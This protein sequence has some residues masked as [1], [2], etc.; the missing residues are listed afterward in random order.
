MRTAVLLAD[1]HQLFRDALRV[2]LEKEPTIAVVAETG[3]GLEVVSLAQKA[4]PDVVCMDINLPGMNGIE[5]TRHLLACCPSIKV[6]GLSAFSDQR[7]ISEM[8]GAGASGYITKAA[9]GEQLLLA[10]KAVLLGQKYLCPDA[11][12]TIS[13]AQPERNATANTPPAST[14]G[15][16]ERQVLQL[17]AEGHTSVQIAA[18]LQM[19]PSTVEVHRRNIMRKLDL[20][21][22]AELT[23][24]AIRNGLTA[25]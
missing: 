9:A 15:A 24:Y 10:I 4:R 6:I 20:H 5:T 13:R 25:G 19:A 1:D 11:S 7:Y 22:V 16:R 12:D 21:S 3:D 18:Q 2:M 14:L 23:K 8:L 17:V